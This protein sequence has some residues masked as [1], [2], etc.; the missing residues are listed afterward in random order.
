MKQGLVATV[1]KDNEL[2]FWSDRDITFY[3]RL[4]DLPQTSGLAKLPN[5][6]YLV[7]T[8][9]VGEYTAAVYHLVK[10]NYTYENK[11]LQNNF[12]KSYKL[13]NNYIIRTKKYEHGY[14]IVN[15]KGDYLFYTFALRK[16]IC[17][18]LISCIFRVPFTLSG[19]LSCCFISEKNLLTVMPRS[20]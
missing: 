5:G 9:S 18:P 20:S 17:A 4:E 2:F 14:D 10:R 1:F 15:L 8:M 3:N 16:T 11:Y 7:D 12:F 13:P 6:Y 19:L